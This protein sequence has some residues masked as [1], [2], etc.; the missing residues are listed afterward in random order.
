MQLTYLL[1]PGV[2]PI[3]LAPLGV[4]SMGR[5]IVPELSYRTVAVGNNA[6]KL[7]NGLNLLPDMVLEEV[8]TVDVLMV[9]GGPGWKD[10]AQ[11]A[12]LIAFIRKWAPSAT[13]CS[14]CTGSM[15]LAAAG[16]LDGL[17]ATTKCVVVPPE[18]S[19]LEELGREYPDVRSTHALLV[20]NGSVITGGGV[21]LCIDTT[22]YLIAKRYGEAAA[23]EIARIM[24]YKAAYAANVARLPIVAGDTLSELKGRKRQDR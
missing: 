9:P 7:S 14:L 11:D 21:S 22:F 20:D 19:P 5:R 10:A 4:F 13:L 16:V 1:Y 12:D 17:A 8:D 2:E 6:I 24:E 18:E 23:Q 3:D 15:I